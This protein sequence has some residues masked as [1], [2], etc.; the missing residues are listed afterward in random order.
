MNRIFVTSDFCRGCKQIKSN[1]EANHRLRTVLILLANNKEIPK[2]YRDHALKDSPYRELHITGD[3]LLLYRYDSQGTL[4][5]SLKI[6]DITN[7]K[8]LASQSHEDHHEYYEVSTTDLHEITSSTKF[9]ITDMDWLN[10]FLESVSDYAS[11]D[12]SY[13][14]VLLDNYFI[15]DEEIHAQYTQYFNKDPQD[16]IDLIIS[17][18]KYC[19][20]DIFQLSDYLY[21]F[22][23][24]IVKSFEEE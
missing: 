1:I 8:R 17:I 13:G 18:P 6:A 21:R 11:M 5:V 22:S 4:V 3:I 14:Y 15:E 24:L 10:D 2:K 19:P 16:S 20:K 12:M 7:H 9:R 23:K